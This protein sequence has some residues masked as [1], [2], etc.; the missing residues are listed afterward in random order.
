MAFQL[1]RIRV[2][3]ECVQSPLWPDL[4]RPP[5]LFLPSPLRKRWEEGELPGQAR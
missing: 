1:Q 3:L 2:I 5:R 4:S